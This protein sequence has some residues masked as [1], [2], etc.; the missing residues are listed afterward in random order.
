MHWVEPRLVAQVAFSEWTRAGELRHPRFEGLRRDKAPESVTREKAPPR[1]PQL[2]RAARAAVET[3]TASHIWSTKVDG[4]VSDL[5]DLQDRVAAEV[6]SA[7][8]PSIRRAEVERARSKRPETLAAYEDAAS[9]PG[10]PDLPAFVE[11]NPWWSCSA[12]S[13]CDCCGVSNAM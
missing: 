4:A 3:E 9:E 12:V 10:R 2:S 13:P 11:A 1:T 5:F 6:A 8:H 7:L